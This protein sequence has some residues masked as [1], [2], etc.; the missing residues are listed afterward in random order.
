MRKITCLT[1]LGALLLFLTS[2]VVWKFDSLLTERNR[3][4]IPK[5]AGRYVDAS[6]QQIEIKKTD[7]SNTFTVLPPDKQS[8]LRVTIENIDSDRYIIQGRLEGVAGDGQPAY[9]LSVAKINGNTITV[10]FFP[11]LEEKLKE[12][13]QSH[14]MTI[15]MFTAQKGEPGAVFAVIT[16]YQSVEPLLDFFK[17][18]FDLSGNVTLSFTKK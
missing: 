14:D 16:Q 6:G 18:L 4:E 11:D 7:F 8:P 1:L 13:A 15:E 9:L 17:S 3:D 5:L 2:C 10:Y 12:L